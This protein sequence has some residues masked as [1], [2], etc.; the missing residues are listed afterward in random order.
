MSSKVD[1]KEIIQE[2]KDQVR[3]LKDEVSELQDNCK[4]KDSVL[5]RTT[6]K[7]ENTLEDLDTST[8]AS[9]CPALTKTP[10]FFETMGKT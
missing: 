5:K 10:P 7:Y 3:I 8:E 1:Y 9:V 4:A 2:Y 6:Q